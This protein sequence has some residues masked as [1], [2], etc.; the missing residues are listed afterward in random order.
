WQPGSG[1]R[2]EGISPRMTFSRGPARVCAT[3]A[4]FRQLYFLE[5]RSAKKSRKNCP[6]P[7]QR[8]SAERLFLPC[9]SSLILDTQGLNACSIPPISPASQLPFP[10]H[11]LPAVRPLRRQCQHQRGIPSLTF[12]ARKVILTLADLFPE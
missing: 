3:C 10:S 7:G 8:A 4:E 1:T 9:L 12:P 11:L 2:R 5:N 6:D